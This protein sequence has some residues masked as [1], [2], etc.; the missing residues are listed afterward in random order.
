MNPLANHLW[1][2]TLF[3][4]AA[5]ALAFSLRRHSAALRYR[6]WLAA[7][8]K[9]LVPFALL[10]D[11]AGRL[12]P[13]PA[14]A[15]V[16]ALTAALARLQAPFEPAGVPLSAP[17]PVSSPITFLL[18]AVWF[19]GF[20]TVLW[21]WFSDFRRLSQLRRDSVP[22]PCPA[23]I[24]VRTTAELVEPGVAGIF[25]PVLLL[26]RD[27]PVRL[28]SDAFQAILA[29]EFCHVQRRDNLTA[30]LHRLVQAIFWF[31]PAVW[32]IGKRLLAEREQACDEAVLRQGIAPANYAAGIL[33][34]CRLALEPAPS[35][36]AGVTG[37]D[38][39]L[40]IGAILHGASTARLT[41]SRKIV[42]AAAA[43][44]AVAPPLWIGIARAQSPSLRFDVASIKPSKGDG[45][46]GGIV[47]HPGGR[48]QLEGIT[49]QGLIA[50]AYNVREDQITG[51]P[52]WIYTQTYNLDAKPEQ[53]DPG[54]GNR[55]PA[56]GTPSWTRFQQRL[57]TLLTERCRLAFHV[58]EKPANVLA[59]V[60]AKGGVKLKESSEPESR[61][62]SVMRSR[63]AITA[64]AGTLNMLAA[65]FSNWL[66]QP[67][68]D[69]TGL[70]GRYDFQLEY[71]PEN[72]TDPEAPTGPSVYT[73]LQ[74]QLGLKLEPV[75]GSIKTLIIDGAQKPSN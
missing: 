27:L 14:A 38:L 39:K 62:P 25:R 58:Q 51:G 6:L 60:P 36:A 1:Q 3:G 9:F 15:Q 67:V 17:A 54:A 33:A 24:P 48:T 50:F 35:C 10:T 45:G 19:A 56:P 8:I 22:L 61:P 34:V 43:A 23:P 71:A 29:H 74:E 5:G 44:A 13:P 68:E 69:R 18:A 16:P 11:L 55:A 49:V 63:N 46:K 32:H 73:A 2:S 31:H 37:A 72:P 4:L 28:T 12:S 7:S 59:M 57:Q 64:R 52:R 42:L 21:R 41:L 20:G 47:I 65:L 40:R 53:P 75:K 66:Q 70:T 26:P 30:A